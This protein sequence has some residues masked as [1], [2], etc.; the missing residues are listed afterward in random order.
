[1]VAAAV[2]SG[3]DA[4]I[5]IRDL[6]LPGP[7]AGQVRVR[8]AAAGICH[9]DLSMVNGTLRPSFPLVLG[10]EASGVVAEVGPDVT[11]VAPGDRVVI[12]WAPPCRRCWFCL[13]GQPYLCKA[14]EGIASLPGGTLSD[15]TGTHLA[16]GVGAFAEEVV[17]SEA[18]MV[19][20][21]DGVPLDLAALLGCA[22]LT[23]VGAVRNTARVRPGESVVV[24]G[25]GGVGLSAIAG[26]RLTG[27]GPIIAVDVSP[28][29]EKIAIA[30]GATHFVPASDTQ[31]KAIRAL[32]GGRG[33]DHAFECVGRAVTIRAA[34]SAVRRGGNV[35]VVGVGRIDDAVSIS[36]LEL[37]HFARTISVS[38]YGSGD[39]DR[40]VPWL[41]EQIG[42]GHL[43][44]EP[45]VSHRI[46][47]SE[48]G[49]AFRRMESG[50]G[51]RSLLVF[52]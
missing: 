5:E 24:I 29:K 50:V 10:H 32:T 1:M 52:D 51:A 40:D 19:P 12:N 33:A 44:L 21:A 18:A 9:S 2:V 17:L 6:S 23:G 36:A 43:D 37:Y 35:T 14:V 3:A 8:V 47:L 16:L 49:A 26:A 42:L 45:L 38:V 15:G 34:W 28:E 30:A 20:L 41:A 7:G 46:G 4:E 11:R 48:V 31:H 25:L 39:A 13:A 22:V 27:A